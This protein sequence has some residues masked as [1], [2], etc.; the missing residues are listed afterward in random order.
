MVELGP[1]ELLIL[2]EVKGGQEFIMVAAVVVYT[3]QAQ[4]AAPAALMVPAA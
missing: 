2:P 1:V 3:F 4:A